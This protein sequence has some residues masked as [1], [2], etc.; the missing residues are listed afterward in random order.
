MSENGTLCNILR[1]YKILDL[2]LWHRALYNLLRDCFTKA[3]C[4][5]AIG[6]RVRSRT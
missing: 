5:V 3:I 4:G 6:I 2:S 1:K